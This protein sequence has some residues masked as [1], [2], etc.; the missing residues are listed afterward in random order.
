MLLYI[1]TDNEI[2]VYKRY[3]LISF[4]IISYLYKIEIN[5]Y[6][7]IFYSTLNNILRL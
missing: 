2:I 4:L 5:K 7:L 1:M 6:I 3:S